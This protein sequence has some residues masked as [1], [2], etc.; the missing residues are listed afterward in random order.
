[1]VM[2]IVMQCDDTYFEHTWTLSFN[3]DTVVS[4]SSVLV[5]CVNGDGRAS[6]LHT[7]KFDDTLLVLFQQ[8]LYLEFQLV[9]DC[10]RVTGTAM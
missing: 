2:S 10:W 4:E 8:I 7:K 1:M 3:G 6:V 5:L 9:V